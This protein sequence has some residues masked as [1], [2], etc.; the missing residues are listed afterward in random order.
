MEIQNM[1]PAHWQFVKAIYEEGIVTGH[2]TFET[3]SPGWEDWNEAH[4][5]EPRLIALDHDQITGWAALTPVSGRCIYAGV[6]EVSVYVG[7]D[8]RGKGV[9]KTLLRALVEASEKNNFWTL[10][11]GIFPENTS[12]LKIHETCGFRIIGCREK[13]GKMNGIWRNTFLLER[14]SG[15]VGID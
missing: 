5:Q 13:I 8:Q 2:A 1:Q 15:L 4:L 6:A 10:Q 7:K 12:S 14:R 11:A 3:Q 9:G